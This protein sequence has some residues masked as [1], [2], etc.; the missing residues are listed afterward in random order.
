M[1]KKI[2][3][4]WQLDE[5]KPVKVEKYDKVA[6]KNGI[7]DMIRKVLNTKYNMSES[8]RTR[9]TRLLICALACTFSLAGVI[10]DYLYPFP[11]SKLVL[12]VCSLSY[13]TI[14]SLLYI[15]EWFVE[16]GTFYEG[17]LKGLNIKL[18]SSMKRFCGVYHMRGE[19]ED[20]CVEFNK[21]ISTWLNEEGTILPEKIEKE[22]DEIYAQLSKGGKGQ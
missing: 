12:G 9:D 18:S 6:V 2:V 3:E 11:A 22:V 13:F 21:C 14:T 20:H 15:W 5:E 1:V 4:K 17:S 10:Y 16:K 19:S 8:F 7:D